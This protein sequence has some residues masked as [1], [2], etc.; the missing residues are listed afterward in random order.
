MD[1][2]ALGPSQNTPPQH[3]SLICAVSRPPSGGGGLDDQGTVNAQQPRG[4]G[5]LSQA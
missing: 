5:F 4:Q 2:G 3:G 1:R